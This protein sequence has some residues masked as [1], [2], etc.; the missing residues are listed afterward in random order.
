M[1]LDLGLNLGCFNGNV[2]MGVLDFLS[3]SGAAAYSLRKLRTAYT[4]NAIRVRRSSDSAELNIGFT[5]SGDL[6]TTALLAHVGAGNGFVTTWYD[7]SGNGRNAT[8]TT[9]GSQPSIVVNGAIITQNGRPAI[10]YD[11]VNDNLQ[12][13]IPSLANQ[14]NISFF[15]V[16]QILT[17]KYTV[18]LGSG[19]VA[20]T[21]GVRWGLFGQG[22][23]TNDGIGWAG[24]GSNVTLG[25]GS[26]V[27]I[28]TPYQAVYTKTPTQ[29]RISLNGSTISTVNDTSFPTST[30]SLTIGAESE[31]AYI[32][33]AL[34][35]EI[36]LI[37][38]VI[39]TTDRETL[40]RNQGA[41]YGITVA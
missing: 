37:G 17:R 24:T 3:V 11:G 35:S 28:N 4:G 30:Y 10:S 6:D 1:R 23:F 14:N 5:S 2:L 41:Y 27:P 16:T 32:A 7:Q 39:S 25:N 9:A 40:E 29:W 34:A 38:G 33:N 19:G 20:G 31:N 26:L 12:A 8:Q 15:G 21:T 13:T 36:I 18:F 22:N